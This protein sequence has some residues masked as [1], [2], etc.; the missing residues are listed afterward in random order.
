MARLLLHFVHR[1]NKI[2][3]HIHTNLSSVNKHSTMG[4]HQIP[5]KQWAQVWITIGC[6]VYPE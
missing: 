1:R 5:E 2:N 6:P 4:N 3:L